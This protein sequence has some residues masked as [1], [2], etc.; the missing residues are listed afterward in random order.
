MW[1]VSPD[2]VRVVPDRMDIVRVPARATVTDVSSALGSR[3]DYSVPAGSM[4]RWLRIQWAALRRA[5]ARGLHLKRSGP[6]TLRM[7]VQWLLEH[8]MTA[9]KHRR[10]E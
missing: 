8:D 3:A 9:T 5:V 10:P 7:S 4:F 6:P 2:A 1:S